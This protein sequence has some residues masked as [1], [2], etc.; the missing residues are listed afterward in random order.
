MAADPKSASSLRSL[1]QSLLNFQF[2][3]RLGAREGQIDLSRTFYGIEVVLS[4][5]YQTTA[6]F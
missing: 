4:T 1:P 2:N 6:T 3:M 5:N